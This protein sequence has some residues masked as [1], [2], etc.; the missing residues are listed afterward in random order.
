[1]LVFK[2]NTIAVIDPYKNEYPHL[3]SLFQRYELVL[4]LAFVVLVFVVNEI[5]FN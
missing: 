2:D 5:R 1:M 4:S 3:G